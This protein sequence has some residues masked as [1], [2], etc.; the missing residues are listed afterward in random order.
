MKKYNKMN[1]EFQNSFVNHYN[2]HALLNRMLR[3][4]T[5]LQFHSIV[6]K[7]QRHSEKSTRIA[8]LCDQN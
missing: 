5:C 3:I 2:G 1:I 6:K 7:V 4:P 8:M